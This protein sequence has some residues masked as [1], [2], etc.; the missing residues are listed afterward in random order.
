M[1]QILTLQHRTREFAGRASVQKTAMAVFGLPVDTMRA[2]VKQ[3]AEQGLGARRQP[4]G[5][6]VAVGD[7]HA[8]EL[9]GRLG[10][11]I[12]AFQGGAR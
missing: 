5:T 1:S 12:A 10:A 8:D 9:H 6:K 11:R 4:A 3:G 7:R 2:A